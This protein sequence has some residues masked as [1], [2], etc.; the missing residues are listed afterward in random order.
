MSER[1]GY[2][3]YDRAETENDRNGSFSKNLITKNGN[4]ELN[5][6]RE[7]DKGNSNL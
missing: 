4:I 3:K 1:L 6:P 2:S 7:I 5:I